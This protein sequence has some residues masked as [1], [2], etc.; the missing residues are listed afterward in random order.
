MLGGRGAGKIEGAERRDS[1]AGR[2]RPVAHCVVGPY[3]GKLRAVMVEGPSGTVAPQWNRPVFN[4][5][6][7]RLTSP[8]GGC[9]DA[10]QRGRAG[11]AQRAQHD[12]AA[13]DELC[14]SRKREAWDQV[15]F[16]CRLGEKPRC[17]IATTKRRYSPAKAET[18]W[19]R[20]QA[21]TTT[22]RTSSQQIVRKYQ[23][24]RL[25]RHELQAELLDDTPAHSGSATGS[26]N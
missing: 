17:A 2:R 1:R 5:R 15:M 3:R 14:A 20:Y 21:A 8:N 12:A 9:G 23:G 6:L 11:A 7:R 25:C 16:G 22:A 13:I 26:K 18:S 24:T 10:V 19:C 4:P